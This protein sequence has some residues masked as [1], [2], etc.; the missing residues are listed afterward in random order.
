M[1]SDHITER[2][3]CMGFCFAVGGREDAHEHVE[4]DEPGRIPPV[5]DASAAAGPGVSGHGVHPVH[6]RGDGEPGGDRERHR[7]VSLCQRLGDS[8]WLFLEGQG[9]ESSLWCDVAGIGCCKRKTMEEIIDMNVTEELCK[10]THLFCG[11]GPRDRFDW[12]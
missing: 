2:V 1:I 3:D 8:F 5:R 4:L 9:L 10:M 12:T 11:L 7:G 6:V